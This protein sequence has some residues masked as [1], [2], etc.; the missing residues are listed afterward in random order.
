MDIL[1]YGNPMLRRKA[2]AVRR[3]DAST[4]ALLDDMMAA[5]E[6]APGVGLAAPQVGV[7]LQIIV[8]VL[9]DADYR[10]VNPKIVHRA[11]LIE[12]TE[13]CLSLPSLYGTVERAEAV[14]VRALTE[15]MKP[16]TIQAEGFLARVLSH[17]IDHLSGK[18]F[19]DLADEETLHW[20]VTDE[21]EESGYRR[22]PTTLAEATERLERLRLE[23]RGVREE[24]DV[25]T[26][27]QAAGAGGL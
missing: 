5:M 13:G 12:G 22:V 25:L 20:V 11:G 8:A 4:I 27:A 14:T 15:R 17:E 7:P 1:L 9:D 3:A 6:A 2:R 23:R 21:Q 26:H 19:I 18:L 16:V 10:L 24:A